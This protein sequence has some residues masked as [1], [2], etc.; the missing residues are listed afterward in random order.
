MKVVRSFVVLCLSIPL[1][2][3]NPWAP[4]PAEVWAIKEGPKGAVVL[5]ERVRFQLREMETIYRVR[6]F[7]EEGRNAAAI[8][9]LPKEALGIQGR[10]VYPDGREIA[11]DSQKDFA[12]RKI[13]AGGREYAQ[14][15]LMAPGVTSDCVVEVRWKE[16]S[17]GYREGLPKRFSDG[18]YGRW[19]VGNPY[20]TQ[21][22]AVEV[23]KN[24][25]FAFFI[26]GGTVGKSE[27]SEKDGFRVITYRNLP[28]MEALPYSMLATNGFPR[29]EIFWQPDDL[30]RAINRGADGYWSEA[31]DLIYKRDYEDSVDK[32][33]AFRQLSADLLKG[34]PEGPQAKAKELLARL[35]ARVKNISMP[36]A[37]EK[38]ALSKSFWDD[39]EYKRLDK[40][41]A[42]G[43]ASARG[44]R[45]M[46]YHLLKAAGIYP[47]IA[48]LVD[49]EQNLFNYARLNAW[50]F[51]HEILGIAEEGKADLWIDPGNRYAAPGVIHPDYQAVPML[52][53]APQDAKTWR[54][55][56][57]VLPAAPPTFNTRTYAY[58]LELGED[59]DQFEVRAQFRGY[60]E[61]A[62][63]YHYL[64]YE[65]ADQSRL[66][67]ESFEKSSKTLV[68]SKAA[69]LDVTDPAKDVSWEVKGSRE[70]ESGRRRE[71]FPFPGMPWPLPVPDRLDVPRS[72]PIVLPYL[73]SHTATCTFEVPRGYRFNPPGVLE[74]GNDFGTV[75]WSASFQP[76]TRKATVQLAVEVAAINRSA[77]QWRAFR[78]YLGWIQDACTRALVLTKED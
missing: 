59:S 34:L 29:M 50:Q 57:D 42:S 38:A 66:L 1:W 17:N 72:V 62:E 68:I 58:N 40:A 33:G 26:A 74:S 73:V 14:V 49:R 3:A 32:G 67:K 2:G 78:E 22:C 51:D 76:E 70:Q 71:V 35:E 60:P 9:D 16:R 75:K 31:F 55:L 20:P 15:H 52:V 4:I 44:M 77:S 41:A 48:K 25:S 13:E 47:K 8:P 11:F 12:E 36:T 64:S 24:F 56:R 46:Y 69:V 18:Y 63:R 27:S 61:Y 21:L 7:T 43:L 6:I 19:T 10:T 37:R 54:P 53:Y 28:A 5:E 39:Y 30:I 65:A 23:A 45:L